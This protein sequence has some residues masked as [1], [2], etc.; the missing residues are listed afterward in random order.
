MEQRHVDAGVVHL[1]DQAIGSELAVAQVRWVVVLRVVLTVVGP[2]HPA[3]R[4]VDAKVEVWEVGQVPFALWGKDVGWTGG[5][6]AQPERGLV[7]ACLAGLHPPEMLRNAGVAG[8]A[9]RRLETVRMGVYNH[10]ELSSGAVVLWCAG[11]LDLTLV[12]FA[13]PVNT[14]LT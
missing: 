8:Q 5:P 7:V 13:G 9:I 12:R 11:E 1:A 3:R 10:V 4:R 6:V 14:G 2:H